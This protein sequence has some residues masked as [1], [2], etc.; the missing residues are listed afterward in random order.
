MAKKKTVKKDD[1]VQ[2]QRFVETAKKLDVDKSGK[3]FEKAL[4]NL[5]SPPSQRGLRQPDENK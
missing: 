3:A 1:K 4:S 5:N 2:S